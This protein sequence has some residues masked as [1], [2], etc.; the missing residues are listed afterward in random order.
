MVKGKG[1]LTATM[2]INGTSYRYPYL[3]QQSFEYQFE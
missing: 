2:K 1:T 3:V